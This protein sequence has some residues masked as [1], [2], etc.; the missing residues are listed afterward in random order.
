[1]SST[2]VH[3]SSTDTPPRTSPS[4]AAARS[5]AKA[6]TVSAVAINYNGGERII[7]TIEKLCE[8]P[9]ELRQIVLVDNASTDGS[10]QTIAERFPQVRVLQMGENAGPC[11]SRNAAV[12]SLD[13]DL[14]LLL[15]N[16]LYVEPTTIERLVAAQRETGAA[17]IVPRIRLFEA[18]DTVQAEGADVHYVGAIRLR[19][20]WRPLSEL[21]TERAEVDGAISACLLVDRDAYLQA[22]GFEELYFFYFEDL[23]FSVRMRS[24]GYAFICEPSAEIYHDR[25]EGVAGLSYRGAGARYPKRRGYLQSRNRLLMLLTHLRWR[26]LAVLGPGLMLY[27]I[28]GLGMAASKRYVPQWFAAWGWVLA[29]PG[30]IRSRRRRMRRDRKRADREL[31]SGGPLP[32][33]PGF[34]S[35]R[36]MG[37]VVGVLNVLLSG[38][39]RLVR[40]LIG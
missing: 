9:F 12:R 17:V 30:E 7:R 40:R 27:E 21:S 13:S 29:H 31:L 25:G 39:Y 37:A 1:M 36:A 28:A 18:P 19:H 2:P 26:T 8:Q 11:R 34:V 15:D 23:E 32:L 6:T 14:V 38:Y 4:D 16:D 5:Q 3:E 24:L 10:T 35:G 33:S 22:G 20:G